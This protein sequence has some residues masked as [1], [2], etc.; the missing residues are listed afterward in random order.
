MIEKKH[1][2]L[3]EASRALLFH[4][5]LS[6]KYWGECVLTTTYIINRLSS[7]VLG[8]ITPFEKLHGSPPAYDHLKSFGCLC[9]ATTP[10]SRRDNFQSRLLPMFSCVIRLV[11]K[12]ISCLIIL[13]ILYFF[14]RGV[15]IRE[16]VFTYSSSSSSIFPSSS[17]LFEDFSSCQFST[18]PDSPPSTLAPVAPSTVSHASSSESLSD[19]FPFSLHPE[20]PLVMDVPSSNP[21][22]L[23]SPIQPPNI[24]PVRHFT[25]VSNPS[26]Y[27]SDYVCSFVLPATNVSINSKVSTTELQMHEPQYYQHDAY[28]LLGKRPC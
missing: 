16:H 9:F 20:K 1:K 17:I 4:S 8:S 10:K 2:H 12:T 15:V 11:K 7:S 26:S 21:P 28:I 13:V 19:S 27:L 22:F 6:T 14:S 24:L 23:T 5:K 18:L 3:L 25:R